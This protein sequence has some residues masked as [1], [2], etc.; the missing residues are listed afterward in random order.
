MDIPPGAILFIAFGI[1]D[2]GG[3]L[4][5]YLGNLEEHGAPRGFRN[6]ARSWHGRGS[7]CAAIPAGVFFMML[8]LTTVVTDETLRRVFLYVG[9]VSVLI[10]VF[11]LL[12]APESVW[13]GWMRAQV[14]A[15]RIAPA[16]PT[17]PPANDAAVTPVVGAPEADAVA[18]D[19]AATAGAV[20]AKPKGRRRPPPKP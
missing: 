18:A 14:S 4:W 20:N 11:F 13:P 10:A 16:T 6:I 17:A 19:G 3:G 15:R 12:R 8:G 7:V 5:A 1:F 2:I 9:G